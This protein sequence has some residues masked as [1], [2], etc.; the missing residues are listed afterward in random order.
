MNYVALLWVEVGQPCPECFMVLG[1]IFV[2]ATIFR[3]ALGSNWPYMKCLPEGSFP[4]S[5]VTGA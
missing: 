3:L 4:E 2:F 1:G 5:K